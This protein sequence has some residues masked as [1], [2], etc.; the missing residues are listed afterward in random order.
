MFFF[1]KPKKIV[2]DCFTTHTGAYNL[3]P[4]DLA[5]KYFPDW[6]KPMPNSTS[7]ADPVTIELSTIK[8]CPGILDLY[9]SSIIL[10]LW[11][12]MAVEP[13]EDNTYWWK[14]A[15]GKTRLDTHPIQQL[16]NAFKKYQH[17]KIL[18]P[19]FIK[20]KSETKFLMTPC[21][22]SLLDITSNI[23]IL[24][25]VVEFKHQNATN[26]NFFIDLNRKEP[27]FLEAG[28][29]LYHLVPLTDKS[30]EVKNHLIT[31]QEFDKLFNY[32]ICGVKFSGNYNTRKKAN[33]KTCPF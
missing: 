23:N 28:T 3:N 9:K 26:I 11:S 18:S 16:G 1:C 32:T 12:D 15:D 13:K 33:N 17:I 21:T 27:L 19:W 24:T 8:K 30:V 25:G 2:I 29:P 31:K 14:F 10:P 5:V 20:E 6:W 7:V 22:W 4:I